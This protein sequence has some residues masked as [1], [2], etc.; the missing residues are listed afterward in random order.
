M[1]LKALCKGYPLGKLFTTK[2]LLV[3][4]ITAIILLSACL[5]ASANGF[6]Q[7]VTLSEK[8][9]RLEKVF[10]TIKQQT[11]YEFLYTY[12]LLQNAGRI[13]IEL[14]SVELQ[15]ALNTIFK[16][17]P[18]T[19]SIIEKTV[20]VKPKAVPDKIEDLPPPIT[21]RGRVINESGEG[22][23][24]TVQVKGTQNG[25]TT[26]ANGYFELTNVDENAVLIIGGVSLASTVDVK[27]NGKTDLGNILTATKIK[28]GE[29]VRLSTGYWTTSKRQATGS[30]VKVGAKEIEKQ[31]VTSPLMALQGRVPGLDI[32]PLTGVAG[33]AVKVEIR[34]RNSVRFDGGYPLYVIDGIPV[35]SRPTQ[36][37]SGVMNGNGLDPLSAINPADIESIE[38]LKDADAT[39]IYGSRGANGVIL[40]TTKRGIAGR[41]NVEISSSAGFGKVTRFVDMLSTRQY[42]DMRYESFRNA[43]ATP[44]P[45]NAPDLLQWD[46]TRYT[47]WQKELLG[48]ATNI[49]DLQLNLNGGNQYTTF[50]FGVAYHKE[51]SIFPG[52]FGLG[53]ATG[54]FNLTHR[55]ND[56]K[57]RTTL[58]VNYGVESNDFFAGPVFGNILILPPVAPKIYNNDGSLNWAN[59]TW[60]NPR[61]PLRETINTSTNNLVASNNMSYELLPG[62]T[63]R[64]NFGYTQINR[65]GIQ[66]TPL[67]SVNPAFIGPSS[68]A[69]AQFDYTL[70]NSWIIEPQLSYSKKIADNNLEIL[71]GSTWQQAKSQSQVVRGMGYTSDALLGSLRGASSYQVSTDNSNDYRYTA[72]FGRVGYS[73][74]E[75][76]LINL[77][78]RRDGSSRFGPNNRFANF[79][80]LG[81]AWIFSKEKFFS[82]NQGILSFGKIRGSYGATGND[83]IGDYKYLSTYSYTSYAYQGTAG[84][85]PTALNNPDYAWE[86]TKKLEFALELGLL[87]DRISLTGAWYRNRS[88]NQLVPFPLPSITGFTQVLSNFNAVVQNTGFE[89]SIQSINIEKKNFRWVSSFNITVPRNKLIS[90]PGIEKTPYSNF[91]VVGQTLNGGRAYTSLGVN[92]QTGLYEV[93]DFNND[94]LI[95][96]A[97][98]NRFV[99]AGRAIFGGINN[100][101]QFKGLELSF[102]FQFSKQLIEIPVPLGGQPQNLPVEFYNNR[103]QKPGDVA[104]Y[105][106][107]TTGFDIFGP[108]SNQIGSR[109][110]DDASFLR[111]KTLSLAYQLPEKILSKMKLEGVNFF[112]QGQNLF[113]LTK[114]NVRLDPE[115]GDQLP[116]LT[117]LTG[118]I[119]IR[120]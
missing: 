46:T 13:T 103:W 45:W 62:L 80:A 26:D 29:D 54:H 101:I 73:I 5:T 94:G 114:M 68:T 71:I 84:L 65:N 82:Q 48:K 31:P 117:M 15:D 59:S 60:N 50:R 22:V 72:I 17:Q 115:T 2:T 77:T 56:N 34:G 36:G 67:S 14:K 108:Q 3:M 81:A 30:I 33:S 42:L 20:V 35:D 64:S 85:Y 58:T 32:T 105:Q 70:R 1:L 47:N 93:M 89:L 87:K 4:K 120:L 23:V 19:Y 63:I 27:V 43:G 104:R 90:F 78:G 16:D 76:Y 38:V 57:F 41:T 21:V 109:P 55:S 18:L 51:G 49:Y 113:T 119:T 40:I 83:Q 9:A 6:S 88:S 107:F 96:N 12:E 39:A 10:S 95:S 11:G 92:P 111:L 24:A 53:R 66:K 8:N 61:A 86:I 100:S 69:Q 97:D 112:I 79:G 25:T 44:Q 110:L 118:G 98:Y 28:E 116:P 106:K 52:D 37:Y 99:D 102:L 91:L 75:R 74:K 7:K